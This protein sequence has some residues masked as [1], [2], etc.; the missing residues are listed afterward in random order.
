[1]KKINNTSLDRSSLVWEWLLDWNAND[2][3]GTNNGTATNVTWGS[4]DRWYVEEVGS[5]NGSSSYV[6]ITDTPF[7]FISDFSVFQLIE[8]NDLT[9]TTDTR[10][11]W[12]R[13]S[14]ADW[15]MILAT[16]WGK[17]RVD[18]YWNSWTYYTNSTPSTTFVTGEKYLIG[19]TYNNTTKLLQCYID[20]VAD[21]SVTTAWIPTVNNVNLRIWRIW[22]SYFDWEIWLNRV[23][24]KTLSQQEIDTLYQES[25]RQFW[26]THLLNRSQGFPKYSLRNLEVG[27]VLEISKP[28]S[29][30]TYIDQTGNGNNWTPTSVV[31]STAGLNNV[32]GVTGNWYIDAWDW[33]SWSWSYI[34]SWRFKSNVWA[35]AW[36]YNILWRYSNSSWLDTARCYF[37]W[38]W[39]NQLQWNWCSGVTSDAN[40]SFTISENFQPWK[41]YDMAF[42]IDDDDKKARFYLD[43]TLHSEQS[44]TGLASKSTTATQKC[45][46]LNRYYNPN[47]W[48]DWE[49]SN[50]AIFNR[51]FNSTNE[52][53]QLYYSNKII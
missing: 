31:D 18:F 51:K 32:M 9:T 28:Q 35:V 42:E 2:T 49:W 34:I 22:T 12:K 43:G 48:W 13:E 50:I 26:P 36:D 24:N 1:M 27:K 23:Y 11:F 38:Y 7:D 52:P 19:F 41:W 5:F 44:Y 15:W 33:Y 25:L 10:S 21:W 20:W 30:W 6:N 46:F 39:N 47:E 3:A 45:S 8:Y 4:A 37:W 17:M 14:G 53:Q 16:T 40:N 29:G